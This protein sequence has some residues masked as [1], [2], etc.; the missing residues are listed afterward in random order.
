MRNLHYLSS[1]SK[2]EQVK[3]LHTIMKGISSKVKREKVMKQLRNGC[4]SAGSPNGQTGT[5]F[6]HLT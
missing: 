4:V 3:A 6:A 2:E 1:N 5:R